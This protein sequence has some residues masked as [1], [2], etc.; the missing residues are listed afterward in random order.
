MI[1]VQ[2]KTFQTY[3]VSRKS[4]SLSLLTNVMEADCWVH[5]GMPKSGRKEFVNFVK[6]GLFFVVFFSAFILIF[7]DFKRC[8]PHPPESDRKTFLLSSIYLNYL[9]PLTHMNLIPLPFWYPQLTWIWYPLLL[10]LT[11]LNLIVLPLTFCYFSPTWI[12]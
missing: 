5:W 12:W 4:E 10:P 9:L 7:H 2:R 1:V 8:F 11:N 3:Y 6:W